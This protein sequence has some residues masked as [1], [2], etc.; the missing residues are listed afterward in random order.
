MTTQ[1]ILIICSKWE[2]GAVHVNTSQYHCNV[3]SFHFLYSNQYSHWRLYDYP[4]QVSTMN[5]VHGAR[6]NQLHYLCQCKAGLLNQSWLGW[7]ATWTSHSH[8]HQTVEQPLDYQICVLNLSCRRQWLQ[9]CT[10]QAVIFSW[11]ITTTTYTP[12]RIVFH[13]EIYNWDIRSD[14]KFHLRRLLVW[15]N[16]GYV[17][18]LQ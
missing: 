9:F 1:H 4:T 15:S 8:Q 2:K 13:L 16:S 14:T 10:H 18:F 5:N 7:L 6:T 3:A 12:F 17:Y 11:D